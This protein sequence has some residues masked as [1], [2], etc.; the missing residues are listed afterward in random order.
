MKL[1]CCRIKEIIFF[2]YLV[3]NH[4]V[5]SVATLIFQLSWIMFCNRYRF[6]L[7][8]IVLKGKVNM[9]FSFLSGAS[10]LSLLTYKACVINNYKITEIVRVISLVKNI[11]FIIPVSP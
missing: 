7:Y 11:W 4:K 5:I 10:S 9:H 6:A 2:F 8:C 3:L 1:M